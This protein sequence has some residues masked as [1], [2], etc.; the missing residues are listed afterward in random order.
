M[1]T[2]TAIRY[3]IMG[4]KVLINKVLHP[5]ANNQILDPL[6]CIIRLSLLGFK[7][8]GTKISISDNRIYFQPPNILQGP[9]RW[10]YGDNRNH[11][12]NLC[13]P[14]EKAMEWFDPQ[15]DKNVQNIFMLAIDGL[16]KLKRS[17]IEKNM[18]IG[19]SNLVC[20]SIAHYIGLIENRMN[21]EDENEYK[22]E[23]NYENQ[24]LKKLWKSKEIEIVNNLL[25]LALEKKKE[26][27][28]YTYLINSI[29]SILEDKD[30]IIHDIITKISTTL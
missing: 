19:E 30:K 8:K 10:T 27:E 6:S 9:V 24:Q 3:G 25:I 5:N 13:N 15:E 17:Y 20:H 16:N 4:T 12:H 11:L 2:I 7:E 1:D 14:I 29:E 18:N 28:E 26:N 21:T 23:N 22:H